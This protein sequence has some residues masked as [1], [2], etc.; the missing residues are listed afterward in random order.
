MD[1]VSEPFLD[2]VLER[3]LQEWDQNNWHCVLD[4]NNNHCGKFYWC[5]RQ[6]W[7]FDVDFTHRYHYGDKQWAFRTEEQ[8][9]LFIL[10]WM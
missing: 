1:P 4:N 5:R 10:R 2:P 8:L 6:D 9:T 7:V 3:R